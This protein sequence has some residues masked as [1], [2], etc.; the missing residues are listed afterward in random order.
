MRHFS[1]FHRNLSTTI[2]LNL[3]NFW[4]FDRKN[5][6]RTFRSHAHRVFHAIVNC[7]ECRSHL[8]T[9][10]HSF[11]CRT[12]ALPITTF[13]QI[14]PIDQLNRFRSILLQRIFP[15][16]TYFT[17]PPSNN[18]Y[19]NRPLYSYDSQLTDYL[20]YAFQLVSNSILSYCT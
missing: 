11:V 4:L 1:H 10:F 13:N 3:N 6:Y 20:F 2:F 14:V 16:I 9:L 18:V 12:A 19:N 17:L 7:T 5:F 15:K 8:P